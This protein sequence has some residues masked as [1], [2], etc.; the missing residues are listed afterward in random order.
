M[1]LRSF[2]GHVGFYR[3]F[4]KDFSK[5]AKPLSNL[6][7]KDVVFLFDDDCLK[8]FN[9]LK[10]S[11]VPAPVI[12]T[13]NWGQEFELMCD[14]SD[15]DVGVVLGQRKGRVFHAI[16]YDN[17]VLNDAQINYATIEKEMLAIVYALEKFRSYLVGSKVTVYTDHAA[18]KYLLNKAD[19][20]PRL[21][22]WILLLLEFD[23]VI[24]DKKGFE[25]LVADHLSRLV[26]EEITLKE[27]EIKDE[28]PDESLF[29][30]SERPWFANL[31]NFKAAGI[32][33]KDLTWQ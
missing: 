11:L 14:A 24:Q 22:K 13:P 27:L 28:F 16:Y 4:I 6:L 32:I 10:T 12:T 31:A 19:S 25:N 15:Y 1:G 18:I 30:V 8:A 7:N 26:N 29:M 33:P 17:K 23:L 9:T 3:W 20:K 21:I 5:I 2:L